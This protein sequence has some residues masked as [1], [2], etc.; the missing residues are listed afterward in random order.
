LG[1]GCKEHGKGGKKVKKRRF[2]SWKG[3]GDREKWSIRRKKEIKVQKNAL[4][5]PKKEEWQKETF[6]SQGY[7][8]GE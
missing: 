6:I 3:R 8:K 2:Q 7:R 1:K 4:A 5:R